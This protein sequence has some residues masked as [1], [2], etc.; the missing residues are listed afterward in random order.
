MAKRWYKKKKWNYA[1]KRG[2]Y[3]VPK[4]RS[5]YGS[6]SNNGLMQHASR[7][8]SAAPSA[9][10]LGKAALTGVKYLASVVNTERKVFDSGSQNQHLTA[11][12]T[13]TAP[14]LHL[15]GM[16]QGTAE[17]QRIGN[18]IL[19]KSIQFRALLGYAG[20]NSPQNLR[21]IIVRDLQTGCDLDAPSLGDL[22]EDPTNILSPLNIINGNAEARFMIIKD[23]TYTFDANANPTTTFKYYA[24]CMVHTKFLGSAGSDVGQNQIYV[25]AITDVGNGSTTGPFFYMTA[26]MRY[27]DN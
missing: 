3:I 9:W 10:A 7:V 8:L 12:T 1:R 19:V 13:N 11:M 14:L 15:T 26:R 23:H 18:S 22:L 27:I 25:F 16:A 24:K 20:T 5:D 17:N 4:A 6:T 21:L 2:Y